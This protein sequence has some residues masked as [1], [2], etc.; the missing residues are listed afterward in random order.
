M[1][2]IDQSLIDKWKNITPTGL[3]GDIVS[4]CIDTFDT[5][6]LYVSTTEQVVVVTLNADDYTPTDGSI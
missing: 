4:I 3:K 1:P 6:L 5:S 2:P